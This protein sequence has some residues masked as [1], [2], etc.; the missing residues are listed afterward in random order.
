MEID[1]QNWGKGF[2][3]KNCSNFYE[4]W[5]LLKKMDIDD[6]KWSSGIQI[7]LKIWQFF[8]FQILYEWEID[9]I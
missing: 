4:I 8:K 7:Q 6:H 9:T 1:D 3:L 2:L 5:N